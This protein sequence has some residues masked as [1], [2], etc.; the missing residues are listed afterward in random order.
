MVPVGQGSEVFSFLPI[1][2]ATVP[3]DWPALLQRSDH[4]SHIVS[5][6]HTSSEDAVLAG[7][8]RHVLLTCE[9]GAKADCIA[10][11]TGDL[12]TSIVAKMAARDP[13]TVRKARS[14]AAARNA[15]KQTLADSQKV[16]RLCTH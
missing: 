1:S 11:L 6:T 8:A 16:A 12:G 5:D 7:F 14:A 10:A 3:L 2:G 15:A 13:S 9:R 4:G